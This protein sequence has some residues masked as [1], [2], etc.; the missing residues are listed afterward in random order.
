MNVWRI[1]VFGGLLAQLL[2]CGPANEVPY[3]IVEGL[4]AGLGSASP[5]AGSAEGDAS[6]P[7]P[8]ASPPPSLDSGPPAHLDGG[9]SPQP[10]AGEHDAASPDAGEPVDAGSEPDASAQDA[11]EDAAPICTGLVGAR[12]SS[13][14]CTA[15]AGD[16]VYCPACAPFAY[17]CLLPSQEPAEFE[18]PGAPSLYQG[19]LGS[20]LV[21]CSPTP[22]CIQQTGAQFCLAGTVYWC[23]VAGGVQAT[24][25][26][27]GCQPVSGQPNAFCCH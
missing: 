4:D 23:P 16:A 3:I 19:T 8:D 21:V 24:P 2:A 26:G 18:A 1:A 13:A 17:E 12:T 7:A 14:T 9:T 6:D 27:T 15:P 5:D 11:G 25:P 10:D 20:G 22:R